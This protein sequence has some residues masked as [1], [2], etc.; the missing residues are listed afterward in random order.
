MGA[1]EAGQL[2]DQ[3]NRIPAYQRKRTARE[4]GERLR[5]S[6]RERELLKLKTI[7]P[8]DMTDAQLKEQR[9]AKDRARKRY[10]RRR[11]G[12]KP[13]EASLAKVKPWEAKGISRRTWFRRRSKACST[14]SSAKQECH[15]TNSSAIKLPYY[16]GQTSATEQGGKP[17]G[18]ATAIQRRRKQQARK[19]SIEP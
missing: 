16:R 8:F 17:K 2:I 18:L 13:R 9:K 3:I 11:A 14:N 7:K 12:S 5:V 15:G 4:L 6:N 10:A 1:D 19:Q